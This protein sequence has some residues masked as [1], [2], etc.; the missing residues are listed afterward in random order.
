MSMEARREQQ[1]PLELELQAVVNPHVGAGNQTPPLPESSL[2]PW[3]GGLRN[4][5]TDPGSGGA[6]L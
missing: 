1:T 2:Q 3:A 4:P 5:T 6:R